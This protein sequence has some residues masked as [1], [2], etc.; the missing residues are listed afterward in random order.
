MKKNENQHVKVVIEHSTQSIH[1]AVSILRQV[2]TEETKQF[3][4]ERKKVE[5]RLQNGARIT[6]HQID[7]WFFV[8]R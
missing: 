2:M 1:Q 4:Q 6:R 3:E 5:E 7:L 8:F